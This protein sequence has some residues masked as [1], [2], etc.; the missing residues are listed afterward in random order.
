MTVFE[1]QLAFISAAQAKCLVRLILDA[2]SVFPRRKADTHG[3][4]DD[5]GTLLLVSESSDETRIACFIIIVVVVVRH[6]SA[7]NNLFQRSVPL[8]PRTSGHSAVPVCSSTVNI[9]V[10]LTAVREL[11]YIEFRVEGSRC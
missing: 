1:E 8:F 10:L 9:A 4:K 3:S 11:Q 6:A 5:D 2:T 7:Y